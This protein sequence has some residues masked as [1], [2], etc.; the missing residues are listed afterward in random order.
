M[1]EMHDPKEVAS[2][3]ERRVLNPQ[4]QCY[5]QNMKVSAQLQQGFKHKALRKQ[6]YTKGFYEVSI[7]V[8]AK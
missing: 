3:Y 2:F 4:Q 1:K 6:K 5:K 7:Q 8:T